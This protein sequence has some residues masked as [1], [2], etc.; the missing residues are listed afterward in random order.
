MTEWIV[1]GGSRAIN[2]AQVQDIAFYA[3]GGYAFATVRLGNFD[4]K[5]CDTAQTSWFT[6]TGDDLERLRACITRC[7][8]P[9]FEDR[10]GGGASP[11][12]PTLSASAAAH[13]AVA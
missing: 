3:E 6:V 8:A 4:T 9:E 7:L 5:T 11:Q 12:R 1:L 10:L 2:L 13:G